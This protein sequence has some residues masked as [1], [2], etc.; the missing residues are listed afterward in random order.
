MLL[1]LSF[2][3]DGREILL[4]G[5]GKAALE[6]FLQ[7]RRTACRLVIVARDFTPDFLE[8]LRAPAQASVTHHKRPFAPQD[9]DGK[10]MVFSAVNDRAVAAE[11][12]E[13]CRQKRVLINSADDP[14]HC[15]FF[16]NALIDRG[17]VTVSVSTQGRFAGFSAVLR[18]HLEELL[19]P[20]LDEDWERVFD[21]RRRAIA[22]QDISEKKSV[23][24][25]I[26]RNIEQKF[27][28]TKRE[29]GHEQRDH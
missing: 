29:Q 7:L 13:L 24:A 10:F 17:V 4:V 1:P 21:L 26:V 27:F 28:L 11:I 16:T 12:F 15:D 3:L 19:P 6:K 14:E 8:A 5:G 2:N 22:L 9:V 25:D 18:R 23:I 20:E